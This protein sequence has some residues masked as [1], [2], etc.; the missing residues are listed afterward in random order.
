MEKLYI[1][2]KN[3]R[4]ELHLSQDELAKRVGYTDRSS[5]AKIETG[6]VDLSLSMIKK[7]ATALE[8]DTAELL[9]YLW[10]K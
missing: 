9:N 2:I 3:R 7:I 10:E 4:L 6:K 1:N 8:T 5:I